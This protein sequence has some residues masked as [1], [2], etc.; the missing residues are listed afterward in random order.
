MAI[1]TGEA[2]GRCGLTWSSLK[3]AK[4]DWLQGKKIN[5]LMQLG[6]A[7]SPELP[8]VPLASDLL[9]S[10]ADKQLV[11]LLTAPTAIGRPF[12]APPG[13]PP[14]RVEMLRRAFDATMKDPDFLKEGQ[15]MKAEITPTRGEDVQEIV[16]KLY[17]TPASVVERAKKLLQPAG[18]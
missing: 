2:H 14:E 12:A 7:K 16:A 10:E 8:D 11:N 9:S 3:A 15:A 4:P 13:A 1:E 5:I 17:A 6:L 18:K